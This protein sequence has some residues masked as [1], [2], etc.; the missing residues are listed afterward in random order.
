MSMKKRII[1]E[2]QKEKAEL[3]LSKGYR[4]ELAPSKDGVELYQLHR[5]KIKT[6]S[7]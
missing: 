4:V 1:T 7:K 3:I 2:E 5:E 6:L